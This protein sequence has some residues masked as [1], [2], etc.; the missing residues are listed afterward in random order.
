ML[1]LSKRTFSHRRKFQCWAKFLLGRLVASSISNLRSMEDEGCRKFFSAHPVP[2]A[3][4]AIKKELKKIRFIA[5]QK[6]EME[7]LKLYFKRKS[8]V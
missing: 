8:R 6:R 1:G 3:A 2:L 4:R 7:Q 5:A